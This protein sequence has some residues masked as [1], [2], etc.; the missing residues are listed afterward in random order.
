MELAVLAAEVD[1]GRQVGEKRL[2]LPFAMGLE[3]DIAEYRRRT[4]LRPSG[5]PTRSVIGWFQALSL[6]HPEPWQASGDSR[7]S[8]PDRG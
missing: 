2:F 8:P 1:A 3:V 4:A 6:T 7:R 5:A